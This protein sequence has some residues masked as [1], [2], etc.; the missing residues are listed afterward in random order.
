M[1]SWIWFIEYFAAEAVFARCLSSLKHERQQASKIL[2]KPTANA[3]ELLKEKKTFLDQTAKVSYMASWPLKKLIF[4][5]LYASKIVSYAQGFMLLAEA[6]RVYNWNLNMG[7]IAMMWRGGCIIRSAFLKKIKEA[8][9]NK[10]NLLNLL[11]DDY[12]LKA[13]G[14]S[15]VSLYNYRVFRLRSSMS[16]M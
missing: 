16:K 14:N 15:Q 5:A 9:D 4:Q 7:S 12:F 10:P 6:S 3:K 2:P 8:Y 13:V 11:L 1:Q